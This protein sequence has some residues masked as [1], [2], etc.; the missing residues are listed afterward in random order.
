MGDASLRQI[1]EKIDMIDR[2]IP[3]FLAQVG[4]DVI[5]VIILGL[6]V[7]ALLRLGAADFINKILRP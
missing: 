3:G 7:L 6:F 1:G 2:R 4:Y 5:K